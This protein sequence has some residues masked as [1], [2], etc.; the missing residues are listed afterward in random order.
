MRF[1]LNGL[2]QSKETQNLRQGDLS[3]GL[4]YNV[5]LFSQCF[6]GYFEQVPDKF[7]FP[8][9]TATELPGFGVFSDFWDS[10]VSL[11]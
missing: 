5:F 9:L 2:P 6:S 4:Y 7:F 3:C 8:E 1:L 10:L 11:P